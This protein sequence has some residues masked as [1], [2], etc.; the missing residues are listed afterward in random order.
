MNQK[1]KENLGIKP[2]VD[3]ETGVER[4]IEWMRGR[5]MIKKN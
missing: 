3:F 2:I 5:D 1:A 4:T